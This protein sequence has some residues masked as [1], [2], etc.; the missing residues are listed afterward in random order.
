MATYM[1]LLV[2][3]AMKRVPGPVSLRL[4]GTLQHDT[5]LESQ[6]FCIDV[7]ATVLMQEK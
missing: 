7:A 3:R 5:D 2:R 6:H 1:E 4:P